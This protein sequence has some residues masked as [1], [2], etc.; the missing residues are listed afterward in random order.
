HF[1]KLDSV[2]VVT[3]YI[4]ESSY[5]IIE[6][7]TIQGEVKLSTIKG[8][9][10]AFAPAAITSIKNTVDVAIKNKYGINE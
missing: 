9:I 3:V 2:W 5:Y 8:G 10:G 6:G 1:D 7:D 4:K